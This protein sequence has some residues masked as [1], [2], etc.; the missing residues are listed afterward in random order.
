MPYLLTF[1]STR[2]SAGKDGLTILRQHFPPLGTCLAQV[3]CS[4]VPDTHFYRLTP[5]CLPRCHS[6][7]GPPIRLLPTSI[8]A[9]PC[10]APLQSPGSGGN[11]S[12]KLLSAIS[13]NLYSRISQILAISHIS[14]ECHKRLP[15]IFFQKLLNS[16]FS[17]KRIL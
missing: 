11:K 3:F 1:P 16:L 14:S 5:A 2:M 13:Q 9:P 8:P 12:S 10:G 7:Y 6:S 4:A 17:D 15:C